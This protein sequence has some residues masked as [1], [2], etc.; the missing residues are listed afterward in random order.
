MNRKLFAAVSASQP[1]LLFFKARSD[2]VSAFGRAR[3]D[4]HLTRRRA[5]LFSAALA[6]PCRCSLVAPMHAG[7]GAVSASAFY[8]INLRPL[9][10]EIFSARQALSVLAFGSLASPELVSAL[11]RACLPGPVLRS[12]AEALAADHAAMRLRWLGFALHRY[13]SVSAGDAARPG[14]RSICGFKLYAAQLTFLGYHIAPMNDCWCN[15]ITGDYLEC[16]KTAQIPLR[17][18]RRI[19]P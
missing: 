17:R 16:S 1:D 7:L 8:A 11:W 3:L 14:S 15:R 5:E 12:K 13:Q 19:Q 6:F 18:L 10:V 2:L 4:M 9:D